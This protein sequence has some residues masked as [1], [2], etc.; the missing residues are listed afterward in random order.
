MVHTFFYT[1]MPQSWQTQIYRLQTLPSSSQYTP[2]TG[3]L[4]FVDTPPTPR[5]FL[6]LL[7]HEERS[8]ISI[9]NKTNI[10]GRFSLWVRSGASLDGWL[11]EIILVSLKVPKWKPKK[12]QKNSYAKR[13]VPVRSI[14]DIVFGILSFWVEFTCPNRAHMHG[15][16]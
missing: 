11:E 1:K 6:S 16:K 4:L 8:N 13:I 2:P 7:L 9:I 12:I 10:E 15:S 3:S 14:L 5:F